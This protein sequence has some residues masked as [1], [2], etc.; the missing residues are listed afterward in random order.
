MRRDRQGPNGLNER[1]IVDLVTYARERGVTLISLNFAAFRTLIDAGDTRGALE[2][3][4]YSALHLLDPFIQVESL[5]L[6]NA[7]FRPGFIP[8]GVAFPSL[9]S[10]PV[11]AAAMVGMEFG[12]GYD[13]NRPPEPELLP[14]PRLV[15]G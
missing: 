15:L 10:L 13:R 7:K 11:V 8:R 6:F 9:L 5:Y 1:M 4:G 3:A 12:L 2:K 14:D